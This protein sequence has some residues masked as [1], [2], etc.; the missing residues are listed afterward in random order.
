M[1]F[2]Q[3]T[4][5]LQL[6]HPDYAEPIE[7][8][9]GTPVAIHVAATHRDERYFYNPLEFIPERFISG[10]AKTMN[11]A[12]MLLSFGGGPR[13][14]LGESRVLFKIRII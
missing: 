5:A 9:Q 1:M 6:N 12:G 7:I 4:K 8:P 10:D 14:C 3:C 13:I 11:E 2:K